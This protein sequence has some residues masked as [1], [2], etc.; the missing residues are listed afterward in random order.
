[1]ARFHTVFDTVKGAQID[2][3]FTVEEEA[4]RDR[5]EAEHDAS[6]TAEEERNNKSVI[7]R[8]S[9]IEKLERLG[10]TV[11]EIAAL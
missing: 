3:P 7:L 9:A 11:E 8:A 4:Q 6:A 5:E 10:L 2:I 1:M